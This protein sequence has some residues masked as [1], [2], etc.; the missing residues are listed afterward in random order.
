MQIGLTF[1]AAKP[2]ELLGREPRIQEQTLS[3]REDQY[4]AKVFCMVPANVP[5]KHFER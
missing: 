3:V 5:P 2:I 4:V 1:R